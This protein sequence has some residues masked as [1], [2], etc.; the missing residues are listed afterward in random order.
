M[1]TS[2]IPL[3]ESLRQA[4]CLLW[5][6][7]QTLHPEWWHYWQMEAQQR[8]YP[9]LSL[10]GQRQIDRQ[11]LARMCGTAMLPFQLCDKHVQL[12]RLQRR[13][14]TCLSALGLQLLG[15]SGYLWLREYREALSCVLSEQQIKQIAVLMPDGT[16]PLSLSADAIALASLQ[17]GWQA[18]QSQWRADPLWQSLKWTL[19]RL[20]AEC[21]EPGTVDDPLAAL[22]R[23]ERFL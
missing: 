14:A 10:S 22:I 1:A 19:P 23:L 20:Q 16:K 15:C 18:M 11:I 8:M 12:L 5:Q 9:Q 21:Y 6:P 4:H 17:T 7:G 13:L 3:N 2:P